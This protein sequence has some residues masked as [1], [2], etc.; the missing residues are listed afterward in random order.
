[1]INKNIIMIIIIVIL[2]ITIFGLLIYLLL[3]KR[4]ED[5]DEDEDIT[6]NP[7][8]VDNEE[9]PKDEN[10]LVENNQ[11]SYTKILR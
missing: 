7:T 5:K 3:V 6:I 11:E 8:L 1:M 2:A 10:N 4:N 9:L